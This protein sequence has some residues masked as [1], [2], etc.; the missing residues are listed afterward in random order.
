MKLKQYTHFTVRSQTLT[1]D[2]L[3]QLIGVEPD[4]TTLRGSRVAETPERKPVPRA[5][6]WD[7]ECREYKLRVDDQIDAVL[8]RL[9]P[10]REA[11]RKLVIEHDDAS[12]RL[13]VARFFGDDEG[14]EE[15][16]YG[17]D[18]PRQAVRL[19][20]W[21]L[22]REVLDFLSYVRADLDVD[23]Y[24]LQDDGDEDKDGSVLPQ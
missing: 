4:K 14:E 2:E 21:Y 6:M 8:K 7:V 17:S 15:I 16:S 11:I 22:D 13:S 24:D 23:E 1:P 10:A 19:F 9:T 12:A 20:G 5:H 18:D 3:T